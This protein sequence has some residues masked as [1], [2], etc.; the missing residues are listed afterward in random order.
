MYH[1]YPVNNT[2]GNCIVVI[3]RIE[4]EISIGLLYF[5][6]YE[7]EKQGFFYVLQPPYVTWNIVYV[8][9]TWLES[10]ETCNSDYH[11][12]RG[13]RM[14][15][16]VPRKTINNTE[17]QRM[18]NNVQ[19]QGS[20]ICNS[21]IFHRL[22]TSYR[23]VSTSSSLLGR[24]QPPSARRARNELKA[25]HAAV[26][27]LCAWNATTA[28]IPKAFALSC[29][30]TACFLPLYIYRCSITKLRRVSN[31]NLVYILR[32]WCVRKCEHTIFRYFVLRLGK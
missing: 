2:I 19:S 9:V 23:S 29:V 6:S 30:N 4:C 1:E 10:L 31:S 17:Y 8:N 24:D 12:N 7:R 13:T 16:A 14:N 3:K 26:A 21:R 25:G 28:S 22:F 20:A 11:H 5:N 18:V 27:M 15:R 32:S